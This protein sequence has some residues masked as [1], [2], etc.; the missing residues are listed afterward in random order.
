VPDCLAMP[1]V[2]I[3]LADVSAPIVSASDPS[4]GS[5]CMFVTSQPF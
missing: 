1:R 3:V 5:L 4:A 2:A